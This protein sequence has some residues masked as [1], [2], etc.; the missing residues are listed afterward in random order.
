MS[1]AFVPGIQNIFLHLGVNEYQLLLKSTEFH[2]AF[3]RSWLR[4]WIR[5]QGVCFLFTVPR[6]LHLLYTSRA[7]Q[8]AEQHRVQTLLMCLPRAAHKPYLIPGSNNTVVSEE[9]Q[10]SQ[11]CEHCLCFPG[12]LSGL[13][14]LREGHGLNLRLR[15]RTRKYALVIH[16]WEAECVSY[17]PN[18]NI[19][20]LNGCSLASYAHV[21]L[22][23]ARLVLHWHVEMLH[24]IVR[25]NDW[26]VI[27]ICT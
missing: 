4:V 12:W 23:T 19:D 2:A 15:S 7:T 26:H 6:A 22:L 27:D 9:I 18:R 8:T 11:W 10:I 24:F 25:L 1:L 5:S 21:F 20:P 14:T 13:W 3:S 16:H 17:A